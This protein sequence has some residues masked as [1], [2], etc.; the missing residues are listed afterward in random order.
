MNPPTPD[1]RNQPPTK[2]HTV[3]TVIDSTALDTT[4]DPATVDA[5]TDVATAEPPPS[6]G[7]VSTWSV[8][9]GEW[10]KFWSVRSTKLTLL[11]AG[12]ISSSCSA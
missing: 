5:T 2:E 11:A 7:R 10:I 9:R 12:L 3:N 6:G 8:I 4:A 1:V